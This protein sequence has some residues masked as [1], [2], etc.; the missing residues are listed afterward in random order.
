MQGREKVSSSNW[1]RG[2]S[3]LTVQVNQVPLEVM[4]QN[5]SLQKEEEEEEEEK[6]VK[7]IHSRAERE[8]DRTR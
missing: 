7:M 4:G 8:Q 3:H 6:G 2:S 5:V 1:L